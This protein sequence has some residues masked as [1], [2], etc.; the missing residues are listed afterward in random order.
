MHR[1]LIELT[2]ADEHIA[3]VRALQAIEQ[4]GSHFITHAEWGCEEGVHAGYL[5]VEA[6][7]RDDALQIVPP[8]FRR[9]ARVVKVKTFTRESIRDLVAALER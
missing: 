4:Y 3:C 2:H 6:E 7:S 1:F 5:V 8:Q 9:D